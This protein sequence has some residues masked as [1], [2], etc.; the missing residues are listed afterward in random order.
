[1]MISVGPLRS[2]G[3]WRSRLDDVIGDWRVT[4]SPSGLTPHACGL[5]SHVDLRPDRQRGYWYRVSGRWS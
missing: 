1:M 5:R 2:G 3:H 4:S